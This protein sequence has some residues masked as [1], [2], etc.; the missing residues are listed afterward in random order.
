MSELD[1]PMRIVL[2]EVAARQFAAMYLLLDYPEPLRVVCYENGT[3]IVVLAMPASRQIE[4]DL[5]K[6]AHNEH[7]DHTR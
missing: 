3:P 4:T 7:E 1:Q 2:M 5:A 6:L